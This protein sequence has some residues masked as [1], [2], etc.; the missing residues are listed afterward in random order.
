MISV[1]YTVE[2]TSDP[3]DVRQCKDSKIVIKKDSTLVQEFTGFQA[4]VAYS[5]I[6]DV[7]EQDYSDC[8]R[9]DIDE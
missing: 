7:L 5:M 1:K 8:K 2:F 4:E 6:K 3:N 9:G